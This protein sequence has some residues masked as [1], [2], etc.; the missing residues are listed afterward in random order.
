M[1]NHTIEQLIERINVM[2]D[3]AIQ[4]H[5]M[6]NASPDFDKSG[7]QH[8]LEDIQAMAYMI[9]RDKSP[10]KEIQSEIDPRK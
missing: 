8:I 2:H 9:A 10:N 1:M 6:R 4:M 7:C 5:R 3:K